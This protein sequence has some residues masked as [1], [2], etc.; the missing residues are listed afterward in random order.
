MRIGYLIPEFPGQT[1]AFFVREMNAMKEFGHEIFVISTKKPS[2]ESCSHKFAATA[3]EKT[4]YVYPPAIS[5]FFSLLLNPSGL[6]QV[7]SYLCRLKETKLK[8]R[9]KLLG[10]IICA[11]SMHRFCKMNS[12]EHIHTH[13]CANTAHMAAMC[14]LLGGPSYSLTLHGDPPVYGV[15]HM[16]KS[17]NAKFVSV[18]ARPL[19]ESYHLVSQFPKDRL[20]VITMGVDLKKFCPDCNWSNRSD[21]FTVTT[22]ARLHPV[23]GHE[24]VLEAMNQLRSEGTTIHYQIIGDGPHREEIEK[25]VTELGLS[26][27][28]S[29]LGTQGEEAIVDYLRKSNV[30]ILPSFGV[31]EASPVSVMEAMAVG[32]PVIATYIGG[33]PDMIQDGKDGFLIPQ[34]SS[35]AIIEKLKLLITDNELCQKIGKQARESAIKNFDFNIKAKELESYMKRGK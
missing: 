28:V 27:C 25:R 32:I 34:K 4:F 11:E 16:S 30:F 9:I 15:D 24:L 35:K 29:I 2:A 1:H 31:G 18:V 5:S 10:L 33:V 26:D 7:I 22:V 3:R 20:P 17:A 8:D 13:S 21:K 6:F 19:Q 12:I 23:K 14:H